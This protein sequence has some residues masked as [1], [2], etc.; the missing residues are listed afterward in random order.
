M[1]LDFGS[2]IKIKAVCATTLLSGAT[3]CGITVCGVTVKGT[4]LSGTTICGGI[5]CASTCFTGS[6]AG[7][8]GTASSLTAGTATNATCLGGQLSTCY[9]RKDVTNT[10]AANNCFQG[11][12]GTTLNICCATTADRNIYVGNCCNYLTVGVDSTSTYIQARTATDTATPINFYVGSIQPLTI[13]SNGTICTCICFAGSGAGLTGVNASSLCGCTPNCFTSKSVGLSGA[14]NGLTTT[15]NVVKLG[16]RLTQCTHIEGNYCFDVDAVQG[17]N[18]RTSGNTDIN[19][20]AQNCGGFILKSQCGSVDTFPDFT[21]AIGFYGNID[22][23]SGFAIYDNRTGTS[24]TG[25][26]YNGDYS[27]NYTSR[28]LVDKGYVDS[29]ATGL[30]IHSSV[31]V[32]TTG[33]ITLSGSSGSIDGVAVSTVISTNNRI[34]VK[35]Q[36]AGATNGI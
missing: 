34:L 31:L 3:T 25:I 16:G 27:T 9:A 23:P 18:V 24:R 8:T 11:I 1:N 21:N 36:A 5:V 19:I 17:F 28:S 12:T 30:N 22:Q 13:L 20:D 14:T 29:I 7:L 10:F 15:S 4:T 33:P 26:V 32:A 6:G 35:N 2:S